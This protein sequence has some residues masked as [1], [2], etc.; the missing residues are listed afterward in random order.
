MVGRVNID[1]KAFYL[2]MMQ[3]SSRIFLHIYKL[4]ATK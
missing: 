1:L 2:N 3:K 4:L